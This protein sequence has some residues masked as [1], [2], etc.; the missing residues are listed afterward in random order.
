[1][2]VKHASDAPILADIA[3]RTLQENYLHA[4]TLVRL[5]WFAISAQAIT[6]VIAARL[7]ELPVRP[8]DIL[9]VIVAEIFFNLIAHQ[10][11]QDDEEPTQRWLFGSLIFDLVALTNLLFVSGS[12]LN[13]FTLL[14]IVHVAIASVML[15][16]GRIAAVVGVSALGFSTLF[17]APSTVFW[18]QYNA[19]LGRAAPYHLVGIWVAY[20]ITASSVAFFTGRL[21]LQRRAQQRKALS[22]VV[23]AG[24]TQRLASLAA[25]AA[26]AAHEISTPLSTIAVVASDLEDAATTLED[27]EEFLEDAQLIGREVARCRM[28]LDRMAVESGFIRGGMVQERALNEFL[29]DTFERTHSADRIQLHNDVSLELRSNMLNSAM[30]HAVAA[31]L[32]NATLASSDTPVDFHIYKQENALHFDIE[33]HGVGMT[34]DV[35][36]RAT[37]P[38]FTTRGTGGGMGLGL[39]LAYSV[40]QTLNASFDIES[41]LGNGTRVR[42]ALPLA[43]RAPEA[44]KTDA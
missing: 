8:T 29:E 18:G 19:G 28:I 40:T 34:A 35:I 44:D 13:P 31:V 3:A 21:S 41:E 27:H 2:A 26:G 17:V 38:F 16:P 43:P 1:M 11:L 42:F 25:L 14:Y 4:Q 6:G 9:V 23:K 32:N 7:L 33:D 39:F 10:R 24:R 5:R 15:S 30:A 37:E 22:A 12:A 36:G 20:I